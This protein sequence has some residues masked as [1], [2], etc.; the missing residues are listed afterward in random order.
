ML[1]QVECSLYL[2]IKANGILWKTM[3]DNVI[4]ILLFFHNF[5]SVVPSIVV[6]KRA[7]R[8]GYSENREIIYFSAIA[9]Q[10]LPVV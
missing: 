9:L 8:M 3:L 4:F 1:A 5:C 10:S 7:D 2:A 6:S